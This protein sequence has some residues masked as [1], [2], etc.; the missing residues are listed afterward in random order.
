[1]PLCVGLGGGQKQCLSI[2]RAKL[3]TPTVLI[4]GNAHII[5]LFFIGDLTLFFSDE[6]MS[7]LDILV[8]EAL[9]R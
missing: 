6:A 3:R 9:K 4:L 5:P 2:A 1:M 7:A 8:F